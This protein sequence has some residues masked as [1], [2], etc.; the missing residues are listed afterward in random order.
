MP[1]PC[2][3]SGPTMSRPGYGLRRF[4]SPWSGPP[5]PRSD[6]TD[7]PSEVLGLRG[8][9]VGVPVEGLLSGALERLVVDVHQA[10]ALRVALGPLEVVHERPAVVAAYVDA[11]DDRLGD[12]ADVGPQV[13]DAR[14]VVDDAALVGPHV[15]S[16]PGHGDVDRREGRPEAGA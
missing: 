5:Q 7:V 10:E 9:Q 12:R 1:S 15:V 16:A 4:R 6:G 2:H 11:A 14:L 3:L 8:E 13:V